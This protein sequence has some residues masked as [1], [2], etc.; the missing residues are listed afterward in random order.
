MV[1]YYSGQKAGSMFFE[2]CIMIINRKENK[3]LLKVKLVRAKGG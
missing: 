3:H 1:I 2:N